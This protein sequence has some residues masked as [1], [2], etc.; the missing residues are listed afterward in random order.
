LPSALAEIGDSFHRD[1][2]CGS[3]LAV[4]RGRPKKTLQFC[5]FFLA[6]AASAH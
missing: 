3:S 2:V 1:R 5:N 4:S 6:L